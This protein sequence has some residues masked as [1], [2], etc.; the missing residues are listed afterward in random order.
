MTLITVPL[1]LKQK[2][3]KSEFFSYVDGINI[4]LVSAHRRT[5]VIAELLKLYSND[6]SVV[7][8]ESK[9]MP[10]VITNNTQNPFVAVPQ[11]SFSHRQK[12]F[13]NSRFEASQKSFDE[14]STSHTGH[15]II[16]YIVNVMMCNNLNKMYTYALNHSAEEIVVVD[17]GSKY[18]KTSSYFRTLSKACKKVIH[19][20]VRPN[21][22]PYDMNY[23]RQ[24]LL[25]E[26]NSKYE[27]HLY[28][29]YIQNAER[30]E[31]FRAL[32]KNRTVIYYLN[33]VHYYLAGWTPIFPGQVY[34]TGGLFSPIP[35][36][37]YNLP[38]NQGT[39]D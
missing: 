23:H 33:D 31:S 14:G 9:Y 11:G 8:K 15:N 6:G 26:S 5:T 2:I 18:G 35:G 16:R 10:Q 38:F 3:I 22:T 32:L 12:S 28:K 24:N 17:L 36:Y 19:V 4:R 13:L 39:Y 27:C 34:I 30:S 20:A 21:I 37:G 7:P 1:I 29:T 25:P